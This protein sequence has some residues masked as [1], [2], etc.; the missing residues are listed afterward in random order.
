MGVSL[1]LLP[2]RATVSRLSNVIAQATACPATLSISYVNAPA[3][4]AQFEIAGVISPMTISITGE[5]NSFPQSET[6][7]VTTSGHARSAKMWTKITLISTS[8]TSGA[9]TVRG[10][11]TSGERAYKGTVVHSN[12]PCRTE[13]VSTTRREFLSEAAGGFQLSSLVIFHTN[14]PDIRI[15]DHVEVSGVKYEIENPVPEL[16]QN[17][18]HHL[19]AVMKRLEPA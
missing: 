1:R 2:Q 9:L 14:E 15:G 10:V 8:D 17:G 4:L 6:L 18:F 12:L 16:D 19:E 13:R 5:L 3:V 11:Y 7:I